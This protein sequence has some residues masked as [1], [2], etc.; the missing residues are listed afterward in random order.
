MRC[1]VVAERLI[2]RIVWR[3]M[4]FVFVPP[5]PKNTVEKTSLI[6]TDIKVPNWNVVGPRVMREMCSWKTARNLKPRRWTQWI[7]TKYRYRDL[8]Q[9]SLELFCNKRTLGW[10]YYISTNGNTRWNS[11]RNDF[12]RIF[13]PY[14]HSSFREISGSHGGEYE[15]DCL[16]GCC[17][18]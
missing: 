6:W 16:L 12:V 13:I 9:N 2:Y 10:A 15:H 14:H 18:V 11:T 17:A 7:N 4:T 3:E 5:A 8:V 1:Y